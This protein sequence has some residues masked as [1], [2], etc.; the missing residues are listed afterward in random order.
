MRPLER[1]IRLQA[2]SGIV[3]LACAAIALTWANTRWAASYVALWNTQLE[4]ALGAWSLRMSLHS[5]VNDVLMAIFFFVIGLEVRREIYAGELSSVRRAALP[6]IAAIGGMAIPAA[7]Y[8][9]VGPADAR[10]GWAVP[11]STDTAFALGIFAL[12]GARIAPPLRVLLLAIAIIDDIVAIIIIAIFYSSGLQVGGVVLALLGIAVI[13]AL[14]WFGVRHV[15]GYAVPA[16]AVWA[17]CWWAG[18]HPTVAGILVGL[19]TPASTW[20]GRQG[21]LAAA[22]R[23][24]GTIEHGRDATTRG[25][26]DITIPMS[27]LRRAQRE[28]VSPVARLEGAMHAW[29]AFAIMPLFAL[30]N[31]G[32]DF[33][34]VDLA[35]SPRIVA[36]IACGL[37][38]GKL[39][40]IVAAVWIAVKLGLAE[41]PPLV[42]WPGIVVIGAVAG[43]GF[44]M[45]LFIANL[46]F[47]GHAALQDL[48]TAAVLLASV[49]A[50]ILAFVLG[51]AL[52]RRPR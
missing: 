50:G 48:S 35:T 16:M 45:A 18:I 15:L 27:A 4:L 32:I 46:A 43:V 1:F 36:G 33:G 13:L 44:T 40:G 22:Y 30:A 9:L 3:L 28:S 37:V 52:L 25:A 10:G 19:L 23:H 5:F 39:A 17:G 2:A 26:K 7:I 20:Y 51:R 34:R 24:L 41:L 8:V 6:L 49:I 12:L 14:Q 11:V 38:V 47:H 42:T 31:A 21:F 29:A